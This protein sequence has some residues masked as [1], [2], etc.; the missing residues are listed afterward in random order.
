M[1]IPDI[2]QAADAGELEF[3]PVA[4]LFPLIDGQAF[5]ELKDDIAAHGLREPI[6]MFEGKILDGRNRYL[7]GTAAGALLRFTEYRGDDPLAYVLSINLH[8]RHMDDSQ[9][10]MVA[11]KIVTMRR[12]SNQHS[13]NGGTSQAQA[14]ALLNVGKRSVERAAIVRDRAVP[15]L[16]EA[17]ERG[18]VPVSTAAEIASE[19]VERQQTIIAALPRD[20][21]GRL[22]REARATL[23]PIIREV[24]AEKVA[25]KKLKRVE[26]EA[27]LGAKQQALPDKRYGCIL[28]DPEWQF[29]TF[30]PDTG[31]D[32]AASNHY[33]T[34]PLEVIKARPV[35]SIAADDSVLFLWATSPMLPQALEVMTAWGFA[36]KSSFVWIKPK[37]GTGYWNRNRHELLLVGTRGNIPAP[38]MGTQWVS[39][40]EAPTGRHSEKPAAFYELIESYY[41]SLPR[42]ELNA[43]AARPG[44][45]RWGN[46][47]DA[48]GEA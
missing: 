19:K 17:V 42:I 36:Y 10:A 21:D 20:A 45:H 25:E 2:A 29:E 8:R 7:A 44:W 18:S 3:H 16:V 39:V 30:D 14:A 11:A 43:R 46:E 40:I 22:T 37:A 9:R 27:E 5:A 31:G 32:R 41:P 48:D 1:Q 33:P 12:G 4:N 47:A 23:A 34:S 15:G 24:R 38:A 6:V 28:A 35:L 26:R 13:P